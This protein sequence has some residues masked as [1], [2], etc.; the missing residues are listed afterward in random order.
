MSSF[1]CLDL[2]KLSI[3]DLE[4]GRLLTEAI[5]K[6]LSQRTSYL[7]SAKLV[8]KILEQNLREVAEEN[9]VHPMDKVIDELAD[10]FYS[11][12]TKCDHDALKE[13]RIARE[14]S[15][16]RSFVP[17]DESKYENDD[18]LS[19]EDLVVF[20]GEKMEKDC[21]DRLGLS[22]EEIQEAQLKAF[23]YSE[24]PNLKYIEEYKKNMGFKQ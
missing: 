9:Y 18:N 2:Y 14:D 4:E 1:K 5:I 21:A 10:E 3:E 13:K 6:A 24:Q 11:L 15:I 20:F 22:L 23:I 17:F 16:F 12:A 8:L 7:T 19:E